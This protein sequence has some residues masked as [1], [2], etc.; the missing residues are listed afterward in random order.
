MKEV[1]NIG[2]TKREFIE[3]FIYYGI[4]AAIVYCCGKYL[5]PIMIPFIVGYLFSYFAHEV[6]KK[7]TED[8]GKAKKIVILIVF[9]ILMI[10]AIF[11]IAA[12]LFDRV[13]ELIGW[14]SSYVV[15]IE[16]T[17]KEVVDVVNKWSAELPPAAQDLMDKLIQMVSAGLQSM[18]VAIVSGLSTFVTNMVTSLPSL[19]LS[20]VVAIIS[21][22]YILVDYDR[23]NT[24][25]KKMIPKK[26]KHI[27][28]G[29]IFFV[30][31]KL[32][33]IILS[34]AMIMGL[35]FVE[36]FIGLL[37]S[38]TPNALMLAFVIAI[39][40]ILPVLGVGTVVIP[41][42]II[43]IIL[44]KT[45]YGIFL[46]VMYLV[47]TVVRNIVEPKLVGGDLGLDPLSTLVAMIVGVKLFGILG[48]FGLPL[49]LAFIL[50]MNEDNKTKPIKPAAV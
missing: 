32:F 27:V 48:L 3:N 44:G 35:T 5:L 45:L 16:P 29:L 23:V 22:F 9:Y 24:S 11:F 26:M 28:T 34:Y 50:Y 18:L 47:I 12:Y 7:S 21:S 6:S 38:R 30:K 17:I 1:Y 49:L 46:L 37:I 31:N 33:K 4:I 15:Y 36:L 8:M 19:F 20:V 42:A 43:E 2:M 13:K 41:W 39:L 25:L 14:L 40:D 10:V